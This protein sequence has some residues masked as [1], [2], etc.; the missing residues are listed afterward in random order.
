M[1]LLLLRTFQSPREVLFLSMSCSE[2]CLLD[3]G[4]C[5][6]ANSA[7]VIAV[8]MVIVEMTQIS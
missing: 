1:P 5:E 6:P 4:T 3:D 7:P 8:Q 2:H